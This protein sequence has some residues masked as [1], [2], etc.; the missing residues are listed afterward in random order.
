VPK[1]PLIAVLLT[2]AAVPVV[3][4]TITIE[5]RSPDERGATR[6]TTLRVQTQLTL[7]LP[8]GVG[9][10]EEQKAASDAARKAVYEMAARECRTLTE[11]FKSDCKLVSVNA[12]SNVQARQTGQEGISAN[13]SAVFELTARLSP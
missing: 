3:A 1:A 11:V 8:G 13:G 5:T 2:A 6:I 7:Y 9:G 10:V 12:N 4:Q